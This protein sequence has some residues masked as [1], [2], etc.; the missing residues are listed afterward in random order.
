LIW[1]KLGK[2]NREPSSPV[3]QALGLFLLAVGYLIIA[4]GVKDLDPALKVSMFWLVTLYTVHTFGELCLSPIG[5]SMVVKLAPVRFASLLMGVWFLSTATA[6][7]FAGDLSS[8]YPE[9]V[10]METSVVAN[11]FTFNTTDTTM[12]KNVALDSNFVV[13][14]GSMHPNSIAK[15]ELVSDSFEEEKEPSFGEKFMTNLFGSDKKE[16][17]D[18]L[19]AITPVKA[20]DKEVSEFHMKQIVGSKP[21]FAYA[22]FQSEDGNMLYVVKNVKGKKGKAD[23]NTIEVWNLKP[24]KPVFMGM[25]IENLYN[26]FMI[27]VFMAGGASIILFL[28]SKRLLKMMHGV[29]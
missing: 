29:R 5:L 24:E 4:M 12:N 8:L 25:K 16:K 15:I 14:L 19:V 11:K 23:S 28:L 3:K 6:N 1:T 22:S 7:K 18:S 26:F 9:E 13:K 10:H 20:S 27:F 2:A 17:A 21:K